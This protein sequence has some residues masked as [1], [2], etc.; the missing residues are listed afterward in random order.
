MLRVQLMPVWLRLIL[1]GLKARLVCRQLRFRL[2]SLRWICVVLALAVPVFTFASQQLETVKLVTKH[3]PGYTNTDHSGGYFELV[4]LVLPESQFQLKT[5]FSNFNRAVVM[6][7]K[8]QAD[9]VLAVTQVDGKQLL[10]SEFP[11]DADRIVAVFRDQLLTTDAANI[12][13]Q[14]PKHRLAWDLA[15]NYGSALGLEVTGYEVTDVA[16][17]LE[18]VSKGRIDVYLAEHA[19]LAL[20]EA[21]LQREH[22]KLQQI[23]IKELPVY[24]G[25]SKSNKGL[26]LKRLWDQHYRL[27]LQQG[28]LQ[29]LH[30][31]YPNMVL[32]VKTP[33]CAGADC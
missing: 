27:L 9:M 15:Y 12:V 11:I 14:L 22:L 7:Q 20:P 33:D 25:F 5:Q 29:S 23:L 31:A 2:R 13:S 19:D 3:W 18:L 16:Q 26:R 4:R 10:L 24:V 21:I 30:Q 6:V 17:G 8:Q 28:Q 1:K 32:P